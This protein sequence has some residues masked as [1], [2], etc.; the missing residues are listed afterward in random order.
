MTLCSESTLMK[1][2]TWLKSHICK[3]LIGVFSVLAVSTAVSAA[4]QIL[5][6]PFDDA[7]GSTVVTDASG[8]ARNGIVKGG[9]TL[10]G[11]AAYLDGSN[12]YIDMPDNIMTGLN[13]ISVTAEVYIEPDQPTPYFIY[14]MGNISGDQ[15]NGYLFTTGNH[16]RTSISTCHWS[17]EQNTATP[18]A[19]L[20]R[21]QW[22]HIAYTLGNGVGVLYIDGKE[23]A[24]NESITISPGDIGSG[25]T[26]ENFLGRSLYSADR[27]FHGAIGDFQVWNG[28]LSAAEIAASV[29][30]QVLWYPFTD[31]ASSTVVTDASGH[32]HN[33][34]VVGGVALNGDVATLDGSS[35]Y[36]D[37]PD[38]IMAGLDA[39]SVTTKVYIENNQASPYFIYGMGN[40]S[41]DRG[42]GYL[43]TTGNYYRTTISSCHWSCEQN[44]GVSGQNLSRGQWHHLAYTLANNV[45][46]LYLDGTEVARNSNVTL[47]PAQ[48]GSGMTTANFL[49]RSLYSADNYLN[50]RIDDFQIWNGALSA[51]AIATAANAALADVELTDAESV[52][53]D[54]AA[55]TV[56]NANDVRGHLY[57]P[58]TGD[59]GTTIQWQTSASTVIATDGIVHRAPACTSPGTPSGCGQT[60]YV[61]LSATV[62]KGRESATRTFQTTVPPLKTLAAFEGYMFTYFTGEG[63]ADGEQIY[64]GLSN[65]NNPLSWKTLNGDNPVLRTTLGE[66]GARDPFILRSPEGDKFYMIATD[67]KIYGNGDW[68]RSQTWGSQS[69]LVWESNDLVNWSDA[70]LVKVSPNTAGNTWAPE[71]FWDPES[72]SYVVFW[73]SKIYDDETHSNSTY[74]KMLYATTRDFVHFSEAKIWVDAGYSTIDSTITKHNGLYYRFTKDERS[75]SESACGK[76]I[77]A[78][79]SSS[80]SNLNWSFLTECIGKGAIGAGEGPLIFK[81]NTEE[82]WYMFIDEFG[83]RGYIPFETTNLDSG[84]WAASSNYSLPSRPRHGTVLPV[85]A[86]EYQAIQNKW[87]N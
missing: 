8:N 10:T 24:R 44:T 31:N 7:S 27:Y 12:G 29:P 4:Q 56:V 38:N 36:I 64:F 39:I 35:G 16:Y 20:P 63:S 53:V 67:L 17:C 58:Q 54:S 18:N 60:R 1:K 74:N 6:Y 25:T 59:N 84:Q 23:V 41:G 21:G 40:I 50:G 62:S 37:M 11:D 46:T 61:T 28:V 57:L 71:A 66:Q 86:S 43:F 14:G 87:G 2:N 42:N 26:V 70:R 33:G 34:T 78:E 85:T 30:Q 65:G 48:I 69:L 47:T 13:A 83:G 22:I 75:A 3:P 80:L 79:T 82:K 9:V 68:G 19:G 55:L 52:S 72:Q 32:G 77:L 76:F 49:G 51:S 45:G 5:W 73:A 81:S 15:G